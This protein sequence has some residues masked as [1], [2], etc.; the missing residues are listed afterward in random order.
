MPEPEYT[1]RGAI[2]SPCNQYRYTLWREWGDWTLSDPQVL[3]IML[4]P[5]TADAEVLDPTV[6]RCLGYA[7]DWG[8]RRMMVANL[9]ALRATDPAALRQAEDPVGPDNNLAIST[10]AA[11]STLIVAAWGIHGTLKGRDQEVLEILKKWKNLFC[12]ARTRKGIPAHPL[13]LKKD[14]VPTLYREAGQAE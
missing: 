12:L 6:R 14:L 10:G 7:M 2:F 3:F 13:Y 5:S 1:D 9:F 4:N 11:T 8:Y